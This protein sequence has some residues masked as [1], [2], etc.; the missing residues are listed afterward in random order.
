MSNSTDTKDLGNKWDPDKPYVVG[1]KKPPLHTRFKPGQ[2]GNP[3]G[4]PKGRPK[5]LANF[6]ELLMKEFHKQVPALIGGKT[7][8]KSQGEIVAAQM[9][10]NAITTK[11]PAYL[12]ILLRFIE[13]HESRKALKDALELKKVN[14]GAVKIDWDDEKRRCTKTL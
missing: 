1:N 4:R 14:S 6:G 10:K 7:V 2:S 12:N 5:D 9:V 11:Q 3:R 13:A 8:V